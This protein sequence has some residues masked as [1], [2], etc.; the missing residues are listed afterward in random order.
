M[1][2]GA[3]ERVS[4]VR[5]IRLKR[6]RLSLF[7]YCLLLILCYTPFAVAAPDLLLT[8]AKTLEK[9]G[10][11]IEAVSTYS[12]YLEAHPEDHDAR[13]AMAN[14]QIRI[15]RLDLALPHIDILKAKIPGDPRIAQLSAAADNYRQKQVPI[16]EQD[17][18]SR[19][20][21]P[22]EPAATTLEY[23]RFLLEQKAPAKAIE[24]YR[25]YLKSRPNDHRARFELAQQLAWR[26][27]F[28]GAKRELIIILDADPKHA[29]ARAMIGDLYLWEGDEES[30]V[31]NYQAALAI[32]PSDAKTRRNLERITNAPYYRERKL[33]LAAK[34]APSS[35]ASVELAKFLF[36][37]GRL[38]EADSVLSHRL[39]AEPSDTTALDLS[40]KI[41]RKKKQLQVEQ[42]A[43]LK[44]RY[45]RNPADSSAQLGL[46]RHYAAM[47]EFDKSLDLYQKYLKRFPLDYGVRLERA[48]IL[49][50]T[51]R[52]EEAI[53]ELRAIAAFD[54]ANREAR[55]LL[56][57]SLMKRGEDLLEAEGLLDKEMR[58]NPRD[59]RV[60]IS[61]ADA[62]RSLGRYEQAREVYLE[63]LKIDST[64]LRARQGLELLDRDL[65]PLIRNL[66]RQL[67]RNPD[68]P[69]L[70]RRL[71]GLYYDA[72]RF[73]EAEDQV[74]ILLAD[75]PRDPQ[76]LQMQKDI[77]EARK[78]YESAAL[79]AKKDS[80][81]IDPEN[82][83]LRLRLAQMHV[84]H[85]HT[86]E[87]IEQYR[88]VY[89]RRPLDEE[90]IRALAD[91][92]ALQKNY[93]EAA[94][95]YQ[96]LADANPSNFDHRFKSAEVWSWA[97][98]NEKA[99]QEYERAAR[100]QPKSLD[101]QLAIA[102]LHR[103][104]GDPY[105]AYDTYRKVLTIDPDNPPA[106]KAVRELSGTFLRGGDVANRQVRDSERFRMRESLISASLNLSLRTQ[107]RAGSGSI[108]FEQ[109]DPTGQYNYLERS[110]FMHGTV[111]HRYDPLT[112][113]ALGMRFYTFA[114]RNAPAF[115]AEIRHNFEDVPDLIGLDATLYYTHQDAIHDLAATHSLETLRREWE[116]ERVALVGTYNFSEK[117]FF[118]GEA[119]FISISDGNNRSD[120]RIEALYRFGR[121]LNVG[122]RYE[123]VAAGR[124]A[125]EYWAPSSYSAVGALAQLAVTGVRLDYYVTGSFG[126][127]LVSNSP[128]RS[129]I[130][131]LLY[132]F[133]G[134]VVAELNY[135]NSL[136]TRV[137]GYYR[138]S[139]LTLA[140]G[141]TF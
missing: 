103:W 52:E 25:L 31:A 119:G 8:K 82:L 102:N 74:N 99:L 112:S 72:G 77:L 85:R 36:E 94:N 67:K 137:D 39:H 17:Y 66:E 122:A 113:M 138:Y 26:K 126:K 91:L 43:Q 123:G 128:Q 111:S 41:N 96:K 121:S 55:L 73:F 98:E 117:W 7:V 10:V 50:W 61:Y 1:S 116:T 79:K 49:I 86:D 127:V 13:I 15:N 139:G 65:D 48:R 30:A 14:L 40:A 12:E 80:V 107:L 9:N 141:V 70:R 6:S 32:R 5:D 95:L 83:D 134:H 104:S 89:D 63:T 75:Y 114:E 44:D 34:A 24:M 110:W 37:R 93:R 57:E 56:A 47:P 27:D 125:T 76:L 21:R 22:E 60:R 133:G 115:R 16:I 130:V 105:S 132:R 68:D 101:C 18:E 35:P 33:T 51:G 97:G 92:Y 59:T 2:E 64:N 23:A 81:Y 136:T 20:R 53:P 131:K 58:A 3:S 118:T 69:L 38:Y 46:A 88:Y 106:R 129:L 29:S 11:L 135:S 78:R 87:A 45:S 124:G 42:I 109:T 4:G 19:I 140:A 71:A 108:V 28:A 84:D 90:T 120:S 100:I 62:L 54:A